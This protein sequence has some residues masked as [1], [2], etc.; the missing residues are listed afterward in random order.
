MNNET[1]VMLDSPEAASLR[2]VTGWVSRTG[3]FY[4]NNERAARYDGCTH[5]ACNR[6]GKPVEKR[7]TACAGCRDLGDAERY[8]ARP[9]QIWDGQAMLYSEAR[10][11]YFSDIDCANDALEE[12]QTLAD[13]C[14]VIC[15]PNYGRPLDDEYFCDEL[16]EDGEPSKALQEAM[17]AFNLA[18]SEEPPMSWSPGKFALE[19]YP[20]A[21][22]EHAHK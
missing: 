1:M 2:T 15:K 16:P 22:L 21:A 7:W 17:A 12:G 10:D 9:R 5:V 11:E 13:L 6:C 20:V 18:L 8:E 19:I 3:H 14:L 4:G